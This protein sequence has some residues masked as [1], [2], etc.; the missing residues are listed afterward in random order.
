MHG[1]P[2]DP[3]KISHFSIIDFL[4]S[5]GY[6]EYIAQKIKNHAQK[7]VFAMKFG[8]FQYIFNIT[9]HTAH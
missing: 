4:N 9:Q 6:E 2:Y 3:E 7:F 5:L 8:T 1:I